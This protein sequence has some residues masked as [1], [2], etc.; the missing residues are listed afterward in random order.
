MDDVVKG[1]VEAD[2]PMPAQE[3]GRRSF[4]K[5]A[6][7]TAAGMA[8]ITADGSTSKDTIQ[9]GGIDQTLTPDGGKDTLIGFS[10]GGD[11]FKDT[12]GHLNGVTISDFVTGASGD[13]IDIT[14]LASAGATLTAT[15]TGANTLVTVKSGGTT[16]KFTVTGSFSQAGFTLASDGAAGSLITHS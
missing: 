9:A 8:F 1:K 3:S 12:A 13:S 11:I 7:L 6:F 2:E 15:A 14:N 10:G 16:T 4:F 5:K